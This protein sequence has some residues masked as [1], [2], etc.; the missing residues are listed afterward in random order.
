VPN[1]TLTYEQNSLRIPIRIEATGAASFAEKPPLSGRVDLAPVLAAE[2]LAGKTVPAQA[3]LHYGRLYVVADSFRAL[4][5]ITP[6]PGTSTAAYRSIPVPHLGNAARLRDVRLS[7]YGSAKASCL[8]LD[9]AGGAPLF[10]TP[11]G[12]PRDDCP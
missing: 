7:H 6:R 9:H 10:I 11:E 3:M 1:A 2:G 4:W 8:R 12:E 5:E